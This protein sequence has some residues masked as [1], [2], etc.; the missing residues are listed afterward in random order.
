MVNPKFNKQHGQHILKNLGV[1]D[2]IIE[3]AR[4]KPTDTVLEVGG[5]TGNLTMK[6]LQKAKKVVCYEIDPRLAAELAKKVNGTPGM[7]QKFQLFVGDAL[8]HD[9]P[10]FDLC[11]TNLPYQISSP[12][13]F[14][15]LKYDF[16]CAFI[17][18]QKEFSDRLVARP[19]SPEYCRLSV[20]AQILAQIDHVLKVSKNSFVPPPKV[21]SSFVRIE[22]RIPRPPIDLGEFDRFLKICF[23]RKNKTLRAN[24]KNSSLVSKI[25]NDPNFENTTPDDVFERVLSGADLAGAR[26]AKMDLD[27]FLALLLEFRKVNIYF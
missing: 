13:V 18:F 22:P 9:F 24:F 5:G 12:F 14:K 1:I 2:T 23:L 6:L 8:K 27:D 20:G 11:I 19:G 7:A 4:I 26:A 3:R 16:K 17:M 25:K 10:H 21:E 15:L